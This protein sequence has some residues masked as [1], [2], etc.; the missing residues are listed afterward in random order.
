MADEDVVHMMRNRRWD[1]GREND[2]SW[3]RFDNHW[4]RF[5][6]I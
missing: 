1:A 2:A 6:A 4:Q 5:S 3:L